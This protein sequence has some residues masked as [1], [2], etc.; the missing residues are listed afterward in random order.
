MLNNYKIFMEKSRGDVNKFF[1]GSALVLLVI[2]VFQQVF[3]GGRFDPDSVELPPSAV[4]RMTVVDT[5]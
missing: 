5:L 3:Y 1:V 4:R 2:V